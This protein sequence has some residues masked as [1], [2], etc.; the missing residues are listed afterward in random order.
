MSKKLEPNQFY[1]VSCKKIVGVKEGK[2]Q[3]DVLTSKK[4]KII[5]VKRSQHKKDGKIHKL[6]KF[7]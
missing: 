2:I 3:I 7:I 1:C 4:R 5:P 6:I